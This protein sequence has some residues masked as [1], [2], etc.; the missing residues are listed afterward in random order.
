MQE[1]LSRGKNVGPTVVDCAA[2]AARKDTEFRTSRGAPNGEIAI[3]VAVYI[4]QYFNGL[5]EA[6]LLFG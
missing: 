6:P 2:T 3:A 4:A 5:S 1:L